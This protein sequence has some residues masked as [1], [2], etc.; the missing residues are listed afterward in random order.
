[1]ELHAVDRECAVPQP[2]DLAF[3]RFGRDLERIGQGLAVHDQRMIAGRFEGI[4]QIFEDAGPPMLNRRSFP[5]HQAWRG[6]DFAPKDLANALMTETNSEDRK[7]RSEDAD[8]FVT[9]PR[10]LR[11][12]GTGRY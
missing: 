4:G 7:V 2:H 5:M 10:I 9:D 3:G 8:D 6:N 12:P 1:M 11:A